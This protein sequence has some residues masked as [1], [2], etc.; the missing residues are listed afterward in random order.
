MG[1]KSVLVLGGGLAGLS[2]ASVL[3]DAGH[4]VTIVE[5]SPMAGGC[6]SSWVDHRDPLKGMLRKGNQQMGFNFYQN[7]FDFTGRRVGL[8]VPKPDAWDGDLWKLGTRGWSHRLNGYFFHDHRG[9]RSRLSS[10]PSD[11]FSAQLKKLPAPFASLQILRDFDGLPTLG[12][13]LSAVKFHTL[14]VLYGE[15]ALPPIDDEWNFYGLCRHMGLSHEAIMAY[16]R[17]TYSI[18][19]LSDFD[20]VGPKFLHLFY[21]AYLRDRDTIGCRMQ[22]DDCNVAIVDPA[23]RSLQE[24][25]V[26]FRFNCRV[27]DVL[28]ERGTVRG[29]EIEDMSAGAQVVCPNCGGLIALTRGFRH[30][31]ICAHRTRLM[32][33]SIEAPPP[34]RERLEADYVVSAMQPHHLAAVIADD[35]EHPLKRHPFFQRLAKFQGAVITVS[36]VT[37]DRQTTDG[38]NLTGLDRD[39]Y[40]FNGTMDL[41]HVMPKFKAMG[42]SAYDLLSDDAEDIAFTPERQ[43][44]AR[45]Q[46]DLMKVFPTVKD[47]KIVSHNL[48]KLGPE[49]LYHRPYP[50]L[51]DR[52]LP[53]GAETPIERLYVAGDWTDPFELGM[54]AAVRSGRVAAN[55]ILRSEGQD[56]L[57]API[58]QPTVDPLVKWMQQNPVSRWFIQREWRKYRTRQA[59]QRGITDIDGQ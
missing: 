57:C 5:R 28:V 37:M 24:Q 22:D 33:A 50:G 48:A 13:K 25:G 7:L 49:V 34:V 54:E 19:N 45:L 8:S 9:R 4:K 43:L 23:V 12:D 14:A 56:G 21:L 29:V 30:C 39:H 10:E 55:H 2:T 17:I 46:S 53:K 42:V 32:A 59:P 52:Y 44:K 35:H 31:P 27:S 18:T 51:R 20:Q 6:T 11:W 16:R 58:L 26:A 1:Q 38:Y 47:G 15:K 40:S 36:R 41:S 3:V